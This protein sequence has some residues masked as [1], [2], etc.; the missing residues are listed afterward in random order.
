MNKEKIQERINHLKGESEKAN[1]T[2]NQLEQGKGQLIQEILIRNG[3]IL[4][5]EELLKEET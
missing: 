4:E 3:R 5:L 1:R 2:L